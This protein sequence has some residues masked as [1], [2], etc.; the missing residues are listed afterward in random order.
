MYV[1]DM[2]KLIRSKKCAQ[3][4]ATPAPQCIMLN[5][6]LM[7]FGRSYKADVKIMLPYISRKHFSV[8]VIYL[9]VALLDL[10]VL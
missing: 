8:S 5:D 7:T 6:R 4:V 2:L 10:V 3:Y 9:T 1:A